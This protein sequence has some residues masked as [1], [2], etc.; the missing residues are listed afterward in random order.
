MFGV[1]LRLSALFSAAPEIIE[2]DFNPLLGSP[3]QVVAVDA[4][5]CV[6]RRA[7]PSRYNPIC[8]KKDPIRVGFRA[9]VNITPNNA[10]QRWRHGRCCRGCFSHIIS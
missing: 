6:T 8:C 5:I 1:M 3:E 7:S 9:M 2:L 4:R 10:P